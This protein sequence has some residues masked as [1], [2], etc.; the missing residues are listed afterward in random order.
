MRTLERPELGAGFVALGSRRSGASVITLG[1]A[2]RMQGPELSAAIEVRRAERGGGPIVVGISGYGGAGKSTLARELLELVS[3]SV[4][5]RGDDFL[6]PSRSHRRS[7]DWDGV[8]RSRLVEEVL[9][10]FRDRRSSMF[11]RFDWNAR[12]LGEPEPIPTGDVLIVDQ[13]RLF[14]TVGLPGTG[15]TLE[16]RR[17]EVENS[18]LRLTKDEWVKALYGLANRESATDVMEGR[19]VDIGLRALGLGI[20][21]VIDFGLWGRDERSALRH[22]AADIGAV[23]EMRYFEVPPAEQRRRLDQRQLDEPHT[24]WHMSD[25]ELTTWAAAISVPTAGELTAMSRSMTHPQVS[26]RGTTG[27]GIVGRRRSGDAA[28]L[29]HRSSAVSAL[30]GA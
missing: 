4:R 11:R 12:A 9:D 2:N 28:H 17:I 14:L 20:N 7:A 27:A 10:P 30:T 29:R 26:R 5:M 21:V 15:K 16:A 19:L 8:E 1:D 13:P 6:D 24:T 3:G 25:A 18:A 23:V 22:A